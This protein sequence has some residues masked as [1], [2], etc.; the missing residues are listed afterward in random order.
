MIARLNISV[1]PSVICSISNMFILV[2]FPEGDVHSN[3]NDDTED[4]VGDDNKTLFFI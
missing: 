1:G 4:N 2:L 3:N